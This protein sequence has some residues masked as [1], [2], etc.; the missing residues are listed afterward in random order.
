[1]RV[2]SS[3]NTVYGASATAALL[4][5]RDRGVDILEDSDRGKGVHDNLVRMGG[6]RRGWYT[7][8]RLVCA[9]SLP[10]KFTSV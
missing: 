1:M 3:N 9:T 2:S 6:G 7:R 4:V 5:G 8:I 10:I